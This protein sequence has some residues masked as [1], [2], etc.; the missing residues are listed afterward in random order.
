MKENYTLGDLKTWKKSPKHPI[1]L[2]VIGSPAGHSRSPQIQNAALKHCKIDMQYARFEIAPTELEDALK[3]MRGHDFAGVNITVPHKLE[4][5]KF[6]DD[7][8]QNAK[9]IGAI[10]TIRFESAKSL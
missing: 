5:L 6:V 8:D 2:G 10:N 1:R 4:A 7:A 9:R 3:L